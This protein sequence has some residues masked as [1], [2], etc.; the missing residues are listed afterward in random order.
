MPTPKEND[1][2]PQADNNGQPQEAEVSSEDLGL[3]DP[4]LE[5]AG[6]DHAEIWAE[7]DKAEAA[8][9][10]PIDTTPPDDKKGGNGDDGD[11]ADAAAKAEQS[12]DAAASGNTPV[13]DKPDGKP[14]GQQQKPQEADLWADAK[15]EQKAAY[16]AAQVQLKKLEQAERSNRGRLS[17]MQRQI[18]ELT[19]QPAAAKPA[20]KGAESQG[21]DQDDGVLASAEWK[22]FREDY[23]DVAGPMAKMIGSLQETITRQGKELSAIGNERR[24]SALAEQEKL[25]VE[26]HPDWAQVTANQSFAEWLNGQPRHI[27][28]AAIR[29]ANEIVDAEEAADVVGRFKA[30]RDQQAGSN[31]QQQ[32]SQP[33]RQNGNG[34]QTNR[35]MT[36]K[37]QL[38]LTSA[39][40]ARSSGPGVAHGIPEDGD[41]K[42]LWK[43]MDEMER[44]QARA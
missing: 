43:Q 30:H 35:P 34:T 40:A 41:P 12:P 13:D 8:S 4:S 37:R 16:E 9:G 26:A 18:N 10:D 19:R 2:Q 44:R 14:S 39:A 21:T 23:P 28:E 25:L 27:R 22:A 24:Q 42:T 6:K 38:Q 31:A 20:A 29:N 32:Q 1:Q 33:Q 15:P 17:A 11:N 36:G 3:I 5:D 7:I